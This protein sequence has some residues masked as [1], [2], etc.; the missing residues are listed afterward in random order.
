M[1]V[2]MPEILS[3]EVINSGVYINSCNANGAEQLANSHI[4]AN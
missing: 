2:S 3:F 1:V 4:A